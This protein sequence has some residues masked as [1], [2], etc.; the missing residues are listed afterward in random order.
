[1]YS[2]GQLVYLYKPTSSSFT[3]NSKK[4]AAEWVGPLVVHE[5][6][7][8][9]HYILATL[10][11]EIL[12]DVFNYNRL[13]PCFIHS[14]DERYNITHL[15][16]LKEALNRS[17]VALKESKNDKSAVTFTDEKG[18]TLAPVTP[19]QVAVLR[20]TEPVDTAPYVI[21]MTQNKGLAAPVPMSN[22]Q[23]EKQLGLLME[24]PSDRVPITVL[25]ARF[26]SGNLE[27]LV[28]IE[29]ASDK[30]YMYWWKVDR[31]PD[32]Q[33]LV[34]NILIERM[35]PCTGTPQGFIKRLHMGC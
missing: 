24:A 6:L 7:D 34:E 26:H 17:E 9:T 23:L 5:I 14:S 19:E 21:N 2:L 8:R 16:K 22:K 32:A 20:Q 25:R 30:E 28:S 11:G 15:E 10:K 18:K 29:K 1:M 3:A 31:Y 13:K 35:V 12:H 27:V 4:I 33:R